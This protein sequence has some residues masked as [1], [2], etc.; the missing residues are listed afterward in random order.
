MQTQ[1]REFNVLG[2]EILLENMY[3]D[4]IYLKHSD[5]ITR[6]LPGNG[7]IITG[8]P[9]NTNTPY[10]KTNQQLYVI[11]YEGFVAHIMTTDQSWKGHIDIK[12]IQ[13]K[14]QLNVSEIAKVFYPKNNLILI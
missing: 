5:Y 3:I 7:I 2:N 14:Q 9:S 12:Y 1:E 6:P 11:K 10:P 4:S 8:P 13:N